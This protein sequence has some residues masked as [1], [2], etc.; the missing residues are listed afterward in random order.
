MM[1]SEA[2]VVY[3]WGWLPDATQPVEGLAGER[4]ALAAAADEARAAMAR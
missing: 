3:A 2:G 1:R 4:A